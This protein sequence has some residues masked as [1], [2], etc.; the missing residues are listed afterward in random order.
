LVQ[1]PEEF[2]VSFRP[3]SELI[4]TSDEFILHRGERTGQGVLVRMFQPAP[5][6]GGDVEGVVTILRLDQNIC[7]DEVNQATPNCSASPTRVL[8]FLV[9]RRW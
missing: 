3:V 9:P 2:R 7:V 4:R 5:E 8:C 6:A 1:G